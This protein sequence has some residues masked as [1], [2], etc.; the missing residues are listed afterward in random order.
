MAGLQSSSGANGGAQE[1]GFSLLRAGSNHKEDARST[2]VLALAGLLVAGC[3]AEALGLSP[4]WFANNVAMLLLHATRI[5]LTTAAMGAAAVS[6][7]WYVVSD[8]PS[9]GPAWIVRNLSVGWVFLPC[10]VL[11]YQARSVWM[12]VFAVLV[13]M[14]FALSLRRLLPIRV[15]TVSA[16][17]IDSPL[18]SLNGL[19]PSDSPWLLAAC[20]AVLLQGAVMLAGLS[21]LQAS[22][23]LGVA[24]FLMVWRWSAYETRA[25]EW[26][27]GQYPPLR[28]MAVAIVV[29]AF[30]LVP[31]TIGEKSGWGIHARMPVVSAAAIPQAHARSGYFGII[32]YP[33]RKKQQLLAPELHKETF[34]AGAL[35]RPL[36][37]PFDGPYFYFRWA[38]EPPG[39]KAHVAHGRPTDANVNPRSTDLVPLVMEAHQRISRPI[40]LEAC[41]EIDVTVTNADTREGEIDLGLLLSDASLPAHPRQVLTARPVQSSMV[42][43]MPKDRAP[44][45]EVLRFAVPRGAHLRRFDDITLRFMLAPRNNRTGAKVSV[46]SFELV[47]RR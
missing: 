42:D 15:E 20:V 27:A 17:E 5:V 3:A 39:P 21:M 35:A 37:I 14:G 23:P 1:R 11:L 24:V 18:P 13:A 45:R 16:P 41:G 32:L 2:W 33:P 4:R 28:H 43:P 8:K 29:T 26:W 7:L 40:S 25:T 12:L 34:A 19:P 36:V 38:G 30:V 47:P 22:V 31:Y 10:F 6:V 46:E 9:A 44:V